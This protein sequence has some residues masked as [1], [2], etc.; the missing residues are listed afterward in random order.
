MVK[1]TIN[2]P[3][4]GIPD[5]L[6][7]KS[8]SYMSIIKR[9]YPSSHKQKTPRMWGLMSDYFYYTFVIASKFSYILGSPDFFLTPR[10]KFSSLDHGNFTAN[11]SNNSSPFNSPCL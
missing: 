5:I 10:A 11:Q 6:K 3:I 2:K 8:N 9:I 7:V 1:I 4:N